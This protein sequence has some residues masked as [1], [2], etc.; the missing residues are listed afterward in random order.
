MNITDAVAQLDRAGDRNG[1]AWRK[2]YA[3]VDRFAAH[4]SGILPG[5][6]FVSKLPCGYT[7]THWPNGRYEI[8]QEHHNLMF[9]LTPE[10]KGVVATWR[11][12]RDV[13]EGLLLKIARYLDN[14]SERIESASLMLMCPDHR[15]QTKKK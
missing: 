13:H 1:R 2:N 4:L 11:F 7:F 12:C 8:R 3:A 14:R 15:G 9:V 6:G 10:E 5:H